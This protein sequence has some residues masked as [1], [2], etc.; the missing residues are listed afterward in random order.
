MGEHNKYYFCIPNCSNSKR[1]P[2]LHFH[3]FPKENNIERRITAVRGEK[4]VKFT[5]APSASVLET[6]LQKCYFF[7]FV[8]YQVSVANVY[9]QKKRE[10]KT[11][12]Q[13][14]LI[15]CRSVNTHCEK[16]PVFAVSMLLS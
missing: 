5:I 10:N 7:L 16:G 4:Y 2:L 14:Y 1:K 15:F 12:G 9:S 13:T 8:I 11:L 3:D 6:Q